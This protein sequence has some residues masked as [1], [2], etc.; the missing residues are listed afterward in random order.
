MRRLTLSAL[1]VSGLFLIA[2]PAPAAVVA[3]FRPLIG[4]DAATDSGGD[5]EWNP[6]VDPFSGGHYWNVAA[7]NEPAHSTF[8]ADPDT[9]GIT[10]SYDFADGAAH[11]TESKMTNGN[12]ETIKIGPSTANPTGDNISIEMWIKPDNLSGG[13]QVLWSFGG[14]TDGASLTLEDD[15]LRFQF[16]DTDSP[17][18]PNSGKGDLIVSIKTD[19]TS[20]GV[21]DFIQVV[22]TVDINAGTPDAELYVN[23]IS[24]TSVS[25][26]SETG[27]F[28]SNT[29]NNGRDDNGFAVDTGTEDTNPVLVTHSGGGAPSDWSGSG[30]GKLG[31][32][33]GDVGGTAITA[34]DPM[35]LRDFN[36]TFQGEVA[37]VNLYRDALSAH[38]V[39][40]NFNAVADNDGAADYHVSSANATLIVDYDAK[41]GNGTTAWED[42]SVVTFAS[43]NYDATFGG[44][45]TQN[46][47][48]GGSYP[49][50]KGA[51]VFDGTGDMAKM[52]DFQEFSFGEF[53]DASNDSATFEIWFRV[54]DLNTPNAAGEI[55]FE[56]G[57]SGDGTSIV[58]NDNVL[59]FQVKH[60]GENSKSSVDLSNAL[61]DTTEFVQVV[62]VVDLDTDQTE[63]W[64][65]GYKF[66]TTAA[67][68]TFNDWAG[69]DL[70][71]IGGKNGSVNFGS[72]VNFDGE[73]AIVRIYSGIL[74]Q[75]QIE[76]NWTAIS[77]LAPIPEPTS[78]ALLAMGGLTVLRRRRR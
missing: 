49:G 52:E 16:R 59:W 6:H 7:A 39:Q 8:T 36:N 50:I 68:G 72:P 2:S 17:G 44:N 55:I 69:T 38:Q 43:T 74:T 34:A 61:I 22:G 33:T 46:L 1:I 66:D 62:G 13:K 60:A 63:L 4:W 40:A 41:Q 77:G 23:G 35:D 75:E 53:N 58:L 67:T 9:L 54:A 78:L 70:T 10:A 27:L 19:L 12:P 73:I 5:Q 3:P 29:T 56:T 25:G 31:R 14:A 45:P 24:A 18:T 28:L 30:G 32:N 76:G 65:N 15:I 42:M 26:D 37:I 51:Y 21:A 11:T 48:P 47:S 64:V 57:G 71:G 20:I